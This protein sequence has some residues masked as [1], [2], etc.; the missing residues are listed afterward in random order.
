M[1]DGVQ[2]SLPTN[3]FPGAVVLEYYVWND[4]QTHTVTNKNNNFTFVD[5]PYI[6]KRLTIKDNCGVILNKLPFVIYTSRNTNRDEFPV[7]IRA[8][9]IIELNEIGKQIFWM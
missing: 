2:V 6:I 4:K 5:Q 1:A 7:T 3:D 8:L 9:R